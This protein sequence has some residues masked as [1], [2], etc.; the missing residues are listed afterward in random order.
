MSG[1]QNLFLSY[2]YIY[3]YIYI[4][5]LRAFRL[6][7]VASLRGGERKTLLKMAEM[8]TE[9]ETKTKRDKETMRDRESRLPL[10]RFRLR[11]K[12]WWPRPYHPHLFDHRKKKKKK[13]KRKE[14][15]SSPILSSCC[16][17]MAME[18]RSEKGRDET[19][20]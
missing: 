1:K 13:K 19:T 17:V 11:F 20:V 4:Y 15:Q 5:S 7:E 2:I 18:W 9:R 16:G 12:T 8:E 3:I 6:R 10:K 14:S